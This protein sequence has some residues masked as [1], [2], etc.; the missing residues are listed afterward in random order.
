MDAI[1]KKIKTEMVEQIVK[2]ALEI[3]ELAKGDDKIEAQVHE[4]INKSSLI[5][6]YVTHVEAEVAKLT[7]IR[8]ELENI[9]LEAEHQERLVNEVEKETHDLLNVGLPEDKPS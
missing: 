9:K 8:E 5:S 1:I 3:K 2:S 4:I 7:H 6:K